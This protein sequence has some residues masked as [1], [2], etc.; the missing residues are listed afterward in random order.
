KRSLY[1][2]IARTRKL[3]AAWEQIGKFM[4]Q[5]QRRIARPAEATE[6]IRLLARIRSL[7][8]GFPAVLGQAGQPGYLV[9]AL[10]QQPA[11]VP[12][13]QT[14]L[15]TQRETLA[16]HWDAGNKLL[17]AHRQFLRQEARARRRRS[18]LARAA[19]ATASFIA[20]YPEYVLFALAM[21]AVT[22]AIARL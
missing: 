12:M 16:Q 8:R 13:F 22:F 11:P 2:R 7:L 1:F 14:L 19:H 5:P 21:L 6:F 15:P 3:L 10:A 17:T 18:R 20:E 9:V 4:G